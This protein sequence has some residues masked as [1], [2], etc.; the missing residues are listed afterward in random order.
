MKKNILTCLTLFVTLLLSAESFSGGK[1]S[2]KANFET[3][4]MPKRPSGTA[5]K[6]QGADQKVVVRTNRDDYVLSTWEQA[7]PNQGLAEASV[8]RGCKVSVSGMC[9]SHAVTCALE[10]CHGVSGLLA[11]YL[12]KSVTGGYSKGMHIED[13]M[14]FVAK[15]GVMALPPGQ[16]VKHGSG[17]SWPSGPRCKF[18]RVVKVTKSLPFLYADLLDM[19]V[20]LQEDGLKRF[21]LAAF[22]KGALVK[23]NHPLVVSILSGY[24]DPNGEKSYR[25][26]SPFL[27]YRSTD[28]KDILSGKGHLLDNIG[29]DS[30]PSGA[31]AVYH[32]II[33]YGFREATRSFFVKNSWGPSDKD[34][35]VGVNGLCTLSFAYI[36]KFARDAFVGLGHYDIRQEEQTEGISS[37]AA[38]S[39]FVEQHSSICSSPLF[40]DEEREEIF[41]RDGS[42]VEDEE[43]YHAYRRQYE[44]EGLVKYGSFPDFSLTDNRVAGRL[45]GGE[46]E[47]ISEI[48]WENCP[49]ITDRSVAFFS[50]YIMSAPVLEGVYLRGSGLTE[51]GKAELRENVKGKVVKGKKGFTLSL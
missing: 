1:V 10:Y 35:M 6:I 47:N 19:K 33:I 14:Q 39:G 40:Q 29:N 9:C 38:S 5:F 4:D 49:L 20:L 50:D 30:I 25:H 18:D 11:S 16:E 13:A 31:V 42:L 8:R 36:D 3:T 2:I 48:H 22:Y 37:G 27:K 17:L 46:M 23:Y 24:R 15:H 26:L 43:E 7:V 12:H 44:V 41:R 45:F 32:A 34:G 51:S 21:R 28:Q